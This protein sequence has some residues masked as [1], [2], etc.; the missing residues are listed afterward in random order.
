EAAPEGDPLST[1]EQQRAGT[2]NDGRAHGYAL[3]LFVG[4]YKG[5]REVYHSGSTAGYSAFLTRFPDQRVSVAVLCNATTAQATQYAHAVADVYL[6][7]RLKPSD[8]VATYTIT[9]ADTERLAG[10]YRNDDTGLA[11][12]IAR[13]G[14]ALK[15]DRTTLLPQSPMVF[16][17]AGRDRWEVDAHGLRRTDQYGTIDGYARVR[18]AVP[19]P[20]QLDAYTGT[21]ASDEAE[22]ELRAAVQNGKLVLKRRPDTTIALTPLFVD[23]FSAGGLGTVFFRRDQT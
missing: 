19:T 15:A 11:V 6:G 22:V 3:G 4:K 9:S 23:A 17:T 16:L 12:A 1:V 18:R 14:D 21:Y 5:L 10:L 8:P 20:Q 13:D 7:D 2:F